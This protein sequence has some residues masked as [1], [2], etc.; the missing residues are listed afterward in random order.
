[1]ANGRRDVQLLIRAKDEG[2]KAFDALSATLEKVLGLNTSLGASAENAGS[3]LEELARVAVTLD[4]AYAQING[5]AESARASISKQAAAVHAANAELRTHQEKVQTL[6]RALGILKAEADKA[7]VGPRRDGLSATIKQ[8]ERDLKTAERQVDIFSAKVEKGLAGVSQSRS[9]L[10]GLGGKAEAV[11]GAIDQVGALKGDAVQAAKTAA[12]LEEETRAARAADGAIAALRAESGALAVIQKNLAAATTHLAN[13][14]KRGAITA[15]EHAAALK[16]LKADAARAATSLSGSGIDSRGRPSLFG[17]KPFELQNLSFQVNDLVTQIASGT[18]VS[19]AFA[20]QIG[21]IIQIFPKV[22]SSIVAALRSGPVLA[23]AATLGLVVTALSKAQDK[24]EQLRSIQ[25]LLNASA[26]GARQQAAA[27]VDATRE[28]DRYG[29]SA[30]AAIKVTRALLKEGLNPE[31][32]VE[33]GEAAR[34]LSITLGI[35]VADAAEKVAGAFTHGFESIKKFDDTLNFLTASERA[36]IRLLFEEGRAREAQ[37]EALRIF[38]EQYRGAADEMRGPWKQALDSLSN[39]W[40]SFVNFLAGNSVIQTVAGSINLLAQGVTSLF[41]ALGGA[42]ASGGSGALPADAAIAQRRAALDADIKDAE[43]R[44]GELEQRTNSAAARGVRSALGPLASIGFIANTTQ[45]LETQRQLLVGLKKQREDLVKLEAGES[46]LQGKRIEDI[47]KEIE[48][49]K[50]QNK[51]LSDRARLQKAYN[52][53]LLDAQERFP[54]APNASA[55][56][57]AALAA[58]RA[59]FAAQARLKVEQQITAERKRQ[60]EE[61]RRAEEAAIKGFSAR[62]VGVESSGDPNAKNPLSS[63]TGLGQFIESTWL[64]LFRR[65]FPEQARNM[66]EKAILALRKDAEVSKNLIEIYARENAAVLKKAGLS[67]TQANLYL[68]HFLGATGAKKIIAAA[69]NAPVSSLLG[70]EQIAANRSILEG[71][72]AGQVRSFAAG[73]FDEASI[74]DSAVTE[75]IA[76]LENERVEKQAEFNAK[77]DDEV[78]KRTLAI[79]ALAEQNQLVG[80]AL[81]AE[82][83]KQAVAEAVLAKQ[84]EIDK[85]NADLRAKGQEEIDFSEAQKN[86]VEATTAAYFDLAHAKDLAAAQRDT[87]ENPVEDLTAQRDAIRE[88]I[89][90]LRDNGED[91]SANELLPA[92]DSLNAKLQEAIDKAIAFWQAVIG[93]ANGGAAAFGLTNEQIKA[94][95]A[96]LEN[97]KLASQEWGTILGISARQ[98]AESFANTAT[99]AFTKF[100]EAVA[101]GKNVFESLR[102]AFLQF[103]ADFLREIATMIL[104]QQLFNLVK[105]AMSSFGVPVPVAHAG[106][107]IGQVGRHRTVS[108]GWFSNAMRYHGGGIAGLKPDEVPAILKRGEEVLTENDPRHRSNGGAAGG[109]GGS[110]SI[111]VIGVFDPAEIPAAMSNSAGDRVVL[112]SISR[113]KTQIKQALGLR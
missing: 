19:Q 94:M 62:V 78:E 48:K 83:K 57:Q 97:A 31:Q 53:A 2:S 85:I 92:L 70:A 30:E 73:K 34:D 95:V 74:A 82:Q 37:N 32:I 59:A 9:T 44:I 61:A 100:A 71:K 3:R 66:G 99:N 1:V 72:T 52:D 104:K 103:A 55:D 38:R 20:Q 11:A 27:M 46:Q 14:E 111:K 90:F 105:A 76:K 108:P 24:A 23:F 65:H 40:E 77:L 56:E 107:V 17:L 102:N 64:D 22:G 81:L 98:I 36:H 5:S 25:G 101:Q 63:A 39:S 6:T 69:S 106:G 29:L 75:R 13:E 68:T 49:V 47:G 8:V 86:A 67:I 58:K 51:Q 18:S 112:T 42:Q 21:Q 110:Q 35:D 79:G 80:E 33:F 87:V 7:F 91:S 45:E 60:A 16:L 113:Q 15:K 54:D 88:Q 43:D 10:R 4:R 50:E 41:D 28:L 89:R 12:A 93:G 109:G 96:N 84:Q 26:D